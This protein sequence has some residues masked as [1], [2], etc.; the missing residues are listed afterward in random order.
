VRRP[1]LACLLA[2]V[3]CASDPQTS[4]AP[5][6]AASDESFLSGGPGDAPAPGRDERE[7][8]VSTGPLT[9][10]W[11]AL[12][13]RQLSTAE[14]RRFR[15]KEF[16]R[17]AQ[18]SLS[19]VGIAG[20]MPPPPRADRTEVLVVVEGERGVVQMGDRRYRVSAG[21]V[22]VFPPGTRGPIEAPD[23]DPLIGLL[24]TTEA[25]CP[26]DTKPFLS[27]FD[28]LWDDEALAK[29]QDAAADLLSIPGVLSLKVRTVYGFMPVHHHPE[30]EEVAFLLQGE[31]SFGLGT[32]GNVVRSGSLL[33]IPP[34]SPHFFQNRDPLGT[35]A[36][37]LHGPD[38]GPGDTVFI[39]G[40][41]DPKVP[42]D[43]NYPD[44][45]P[46]GGD[47]QPNGN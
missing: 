37:V 20:R 2:L 39:E 5:D 3:A 30:H 8:H 1:A 12:I 14:G 34:E 41:P 36:L 31:G 9:T 29:N 21:S 24:I 27:S 47:P 32:S 42:D 35:R 22:A 28:R 17:G 40:H 16:H 10:H 44:L 6:P 46:Q 18:F 33:V 26:P 38:L 13:R 45:P 4:E 11:D 19:V 23:R 7:V 15:L 43:L 25:P